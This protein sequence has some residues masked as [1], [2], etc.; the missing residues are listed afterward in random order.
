MIERPLFG[1]MRL[2]AG[3]PQRRMA[4]ALVIVFGLAAP[5]LWWALRPSLPAP[6]PPLLPAPQTTIAS[7]PSTPEPAA[8]PGAAVAIPSP[9]TSP[10]AQRARLQGATIQPT[11][12]SRS[13][14]PSTA[15]PVTVSSSPPASPPPSVDADAGAIEARVPDP[16]RPTAAP[17]MA[18]SP[19]P[20]A[21][22]PSAAPPPASP[23][24]RGSLVM[25]GPG[26]TLPV[27]RRCPAP[28][29][30]SMAA[31]LGTTAVVELRLLV[32]E[33][34]AVLETEV[35]SGPQQFAKAA[36]Q[37]AARWRYVPASKDGVP[38]KMWLLVPIRFVP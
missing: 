13:P 1:Q 7:A 28:A 8:S 27:C 24:L 10:L 22:S 20:P 15:A 2:E 23:T 9:S 36:E 16:Q 11:A 12:L 6:E 3:R 35:L 31:R 34:G 33:M 14:S 5:A 4:A 21:T 17:P 32:D 18:D 37:A 25:P 30:P 38:V 26:V 19:P 29:Y